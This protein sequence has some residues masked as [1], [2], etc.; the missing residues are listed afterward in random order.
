MAA[1]GVCQSSD[2]EAQPQILQRLLKDSCFS[3]NK[4]VSLYLII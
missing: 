2:E 3:T 4:M 1:D